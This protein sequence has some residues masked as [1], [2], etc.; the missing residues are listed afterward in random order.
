MS[1]SGRTDDKGWPSELVLPPSAPF[2]W[3]GVGLPQLSSELRPQLP[4]PEGSLS[5]T[6]GGLSRPV[7]NVA[8]WTMGHRD[9]CICT[10]SQPTLHP[11]GVIAIPRV[12]VP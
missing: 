9:L 12:T 11:L 7:P 5:L 3:V 2:R 6:L 10:G 1:W 4:A 8:R